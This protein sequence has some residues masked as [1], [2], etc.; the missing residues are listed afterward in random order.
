M[1]I[2]QKRIF[3]RSQFVTKTSLSVNKETFM[4]MRRIL[5]SVEI[6]E[7]LSSFKNYVCIQS[8]QTASKLIVP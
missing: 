2:K 8:L 7:L 1:L 6:T 5:V 4:Q 3:W